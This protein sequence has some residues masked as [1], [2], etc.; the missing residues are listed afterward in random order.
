[1]SSDNSS[2]RKLQG[3]ELVNVVRDNREKPWLEIIER[4]G[5]L[6]SQF[7]VPGPNGWTPVKAFKRV[8]LFREFYTEYAKAAEVLIRDAYEIKYWNRL[9]WKE[10]EGPISEGEDAKNYS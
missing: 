1:M 7:C 9:N 6:G 4:C 3:E 5:Y 8:Q 2:I 10:K